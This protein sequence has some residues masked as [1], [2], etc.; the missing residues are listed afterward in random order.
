MSKLIIDA[1]IDL[2]PPKIYT[3]FA[4]TNFAIQ[5]IP[6]EYTE[7]LKNKKFLESFLKGHIIKGRL[8]L[9]NLDSSEPIEVNALNNKTIKLEKGDDKGSVTFSIGKA[10]AVPH[11]IESID[12]SRA[13]I[14]LI[15]SVIGINEG[16]D[17]NYYFLKSISNKAMLRLFSYDL[18]IS[19]Q[20]FD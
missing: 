15:D 10:K 4:P 18:F 11:D 14:Y 9:N 20:L 16:N 12:A 3:L 7:L 5:N 13:L 1:G 6:K 17:S 8:L 2:P 19:L